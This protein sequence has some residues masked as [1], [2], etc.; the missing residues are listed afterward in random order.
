[1]NDKVKEY[2]D[3]H[4]ETGSHASELPKEA[5]PQ[6]IDKNPARAFEALMRQDAR[7]RQARR[8]FHAEAQPDYKASAG[9]V[10]AGRKEQLKASIMDENQPP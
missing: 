9:T 7:D 2:I 5:T 8:H 3:L 1:M 10:F 6:Q 4:H